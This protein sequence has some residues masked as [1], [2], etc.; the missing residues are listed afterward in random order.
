MKVLLKNARILC[1]GSPF[2]L[3]VRDI[4]INQGIIESIAEPGNFSAD[5]IISHDNLH[6][7]IGWLDTFSHFN[8]PGNEYREDL[9][10]GSDAASAGGF[11]DV[12]LLPNTRPST[13]TRAQVEYLAK[14]SGHLPARLHPIASVSKDCM[15][16]E[17]A[18]MYELKESGAV[19]FSD[20]LKPVQDPGLL[21]KALQ[22]V[23]PVS[24][25]IIQVPSDKTISPGGLMHEGIMSTRLG[26]PGKPAMAEEIMIARDL[27]LLRYTGS[28]LHISGVSTAKGL[29]LIRQAKSEGLP[30]TCSVTPYHCHF[31]DEDLAGYD[32]RL[33]TDPPLRSREDMM[34][35]RKGLLDGTVDA[36]AS[37]HLPLHEDEKN[38]EFEHALPGMEGLESLFG[39]MNQLFDKTEDLIQLLTV[40]NRR[41]F[42][43]PVPE[44]KQGASACLTLFDPAPESVFSESM[45]RSKSR[46][47]AF[48]GKKLRGLVLGTIIHSKVNIRPS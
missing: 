26:L 5:Q 44:L 40:N 2:H 29:D 30:I 31:C 8:D 3:S 42:D 36:I 19:A 45:I 9:K 24:G 1:P 47:N 12:M 20:G 27:E 48:I 15:G 37:H 43:L 17:L 34:A 33:K 32:S 41:I 4:I 21:L 35:L 6:V 23:I 10:S 14:A 39:A 25:T 13:S 7:S 18:E 28:R 11:T 16:K 46:N 38:C 22:Y